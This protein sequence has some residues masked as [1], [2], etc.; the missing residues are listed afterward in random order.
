MLLSVILLFL[1]P[2]I[3]NKDITDDSM[4]TSAKIENN[5]LIVETDLPF[6]RSYNGYMMGS[7]TTNNA[8]ELVI[9]TTLDLSKDENKIIEIPLE[10][11]WLKEITTIEL[12]SSTFGYRKIYSTE[13][14][15]TV[16]SNNP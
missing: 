4:I 5:I 15:D 1:L 6:Y 14:R 9:S 12:T 8:V 2:R 10:Q 3:I 16:D 13:E 11:E 7:S